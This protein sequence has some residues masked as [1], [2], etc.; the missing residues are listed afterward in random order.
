M[1]AAWWSDTFYGILDESIEE[2]EGVNKP[3][4]EAEIPSEAP[5]EENFGDAFGRS[6]AAL[7]LNGSIPTSRRNML[8]KMVYGARL[9]FL[10]SRVAIVYL[11]TL[12]R[13]LLKLLLHHWIPFMKCGPVVV[14]VCFD[15]FPTYF[16][17]Q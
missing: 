2:S 7:A 4:N 6:N 16:L 8:P 17:D 12:L 15:N 5:Y 13:E 14:A 9:V 10:D 1:W 11:P 3:D